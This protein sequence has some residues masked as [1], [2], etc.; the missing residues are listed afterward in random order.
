MVTF[1]DIPY[2]KAWSLG[3]NQEAMMQE[4]VHLPGIEEMWNSKEIEERML[5][6]ID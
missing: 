4:I 1:S 5:K 3:Q 2:A 6:M